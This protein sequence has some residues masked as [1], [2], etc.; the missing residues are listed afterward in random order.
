MNFAFREL[1]FWSSG[2]LVCLMHRYKYILL[3]LTNDKKKLWR[4]VKKKIGKDAP[5]N[6]DICLLET[7]TVKNLEDDEIKYDTFIPNEKEYIENIALVYQQHMGN[8]SRID[9]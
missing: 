1:V 5:C 3:R 6:S 4:E 2:D 9:R 8:I 7:P